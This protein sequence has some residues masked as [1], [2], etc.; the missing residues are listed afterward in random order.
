MYDF[1]KTNFR[2]FMW[3]ML[4]VFALFTGIYIYG[5]WYGYLTDD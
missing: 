4:I 5:T 3:A 1:Q 2:S